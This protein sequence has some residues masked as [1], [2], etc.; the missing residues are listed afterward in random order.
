MINVLM[1]AVLAV[2]VIGYPADHS[3]SRAVDV[4]ALPSRD[5]VVA[6]SARHDLPALA[7]R[8]AFEAP[9]SVDGAR[10]SVVGLGV[11]EVEINGRRVESS[12][13]KPG[14][15]MSF[16]R[17]EFVFE[18][19]PL[20]VSGGNEIVIT[21][22]DSYW[23]DEIA[24][25]D[26]SHWIDGGGMAHERPNGFAVSLVT[27]DGRALGDGD[28]WEF[29]DDGPLVNASIYDGEVYDARLEDLA[30][31]RWR[32]A[33]RLPMTVAVEPARAEVHARTDLAFA[34]PAD[35]TVAPG[36]RRV[37]DFGQ[38]CSAREEFRIRGEAGTVVTIR[39][40]EILNGDGTGYF[41]NLRSAKAT[42]TYILKGGGVE[43]F[44]PRFTYYGYRY[45]EIS[46]S[47]PVVFESIASVPLTS[48]AKGLETGSIETSNPDV[49]RIIA[50]A[51]WSLRSN[52]LSVPTDCSQRNERLPWMGDACIS[53]AA[54][55]WLWDTRDFYAK[56]FRDQRDA[57]LADGR[58][59]SISPGNP[60]WGEPWR[61]GM[62]IWSDAGILMPYQLWH[63]FGDLD[64][65]REHYPSMKEYAR[66]LE[67]ADG[68]YL[69]DWSDWLA[70]QRTGFW[71]QDL[72]YGSDPDT[73]TFLAFACRIEDFRAMAVFAGRLGYDD[74]AR[75]Y[76][77]L[78]DRSL[79]ELHEL[80][81]EECGRVKAKYSCQVTLALTLTKQLFPNESGRFAALNDL[82]TGI[83]AAGGRLLTGIVGTK[84][85][86]FAL[87]ENGRADLAYKLLLNRS[88][89]SWLYMV[90]NGATTLWEHWDGIMSDGTPNTPTMNSFNHSEF[91]S[92]LDW[93]YRTMAGI[94]PNPGKG[95]FDDIELKPV[96]DPRIRWVKASYRTARGMIRVHSYYDDNGEWHFDY[97]L[98]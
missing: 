75:H 21:T 85:I 41:D 46:V 81:F 62:A 31:A 7:F 83:E 11:F 52:Q 3:F 79:A 55:S 94:R 58:F 36:E 37:I 43:T 1:M 16:A 91:A 84:H 24:G 74:D 13:L 6:T 22:A 66:W 67:E 19:A 65:I 89:P 90:D 15:T 34:G 93:M 64:L 45:A 51:E 39:H 56:Q 76:R 12:E 77:E 69:S 54:S 35:F 72:P 44:T 92:V 2:S 49:N 53:V 78:A 80:A 82:V 9:A 61:S 40:A 97:S 14:F 8:R 10:L 29:T 48:V 18:V 60:V 96:P 59:A 20:L 30:A 25:V 28:G 47:A 71:K 86:L 87:S 42:T 38:N 68:P 95:G 70:F 23:R 26:D 98:P 5:F 4:A 88:C 63:H 33:E 73:A 57:Q 50:C 32:P 17:Q 27:A